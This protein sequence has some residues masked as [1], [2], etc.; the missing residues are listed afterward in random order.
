MWRGFCG[1]RRGMFAGFA[2][3]LACRR[4]GS[5]RACGSSP[6]TLWRGLRSV[7]S[8]L[9]AAAADK[10]DQALKDRRGEMNIGQA[11]HGPSGEGCLEILVH[12]GDE[13]GSA[14]VASL[15][16]DAAFD[17]DERS[18]RLVSEVSPPAS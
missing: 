5:G 17:F 12:V 1:V 7:G 10:L 2:E 4:S 13:A 6:T 3:I 16:P 18:A 9:S 11:N 15:D 8:S 14:V